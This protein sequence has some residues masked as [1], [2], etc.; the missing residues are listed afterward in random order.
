MHEATSGRPGAVLLDV[1]KDLSASVGGSSTAEFALTA[2]TKPGTV[3]TSKIKI[4][5]DAWA[6]AKRPV[7][8][9]WSR[10]FDSK[11]L[12]PAF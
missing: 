7:I 9:G 5:M 11:S 12:G 2:D 1:P 8:I 10:S 3:N 4:I 6:K